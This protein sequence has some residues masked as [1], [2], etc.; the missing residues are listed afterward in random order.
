[1]DGWFVSLSLSLLVDSFH[2]PWVVRRSPSLSLR[3]LFALWCRITI[4]DTDDGD[5][6]WRQQ[7][8]CE[9]SVRDVRNVDDLNY[10]VFF[11]LH[12]INGDL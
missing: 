3:T 8:V 11:H 6:G 12:L 4:T 2:R 7:S 5:H 1:M 10:F 9:I